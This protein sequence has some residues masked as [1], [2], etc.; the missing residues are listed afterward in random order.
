[1]LR[2][3]FWIS[4]GY[5]TTKRIINK[6]I[7]CKKLYGRAVKINQSDY[8]DYLINPS[9]IP[10][11]RIALDHIGPVTILNDVGQKCKGYVLIV[12]CLFTR[13][14]NLISSTR[15]NAEGFLEALQSHIFTYGM[16]EFILSDNGSPI[17]SSINLIQATLDDPDVK[18]FLRQRGIKPLLFE[19]YPP[20]ASYLG[21][22]VESLVK[23]VKNMFHVS[24]G[25]NLL[26]FSKF[27]LFIKECQMLI[28]KRPIAFKLKS[29][30]G[31]PE[32]VSRV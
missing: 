23:Q 4:S 14:V 2:E 28:N 29:N 22:L 24:L 25:K 8:K 11:R 30:E 20:N 31:Y 3:R 13:A 1:M 10:Y 9:H 6:C 15:I 16:P 26:T 19:P 7:Q 32:S 12:T 21:G 17:V 18:N 27:Y 5:M